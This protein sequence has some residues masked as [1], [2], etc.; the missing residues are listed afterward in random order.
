[1]KYFF[2]PFKGK[3]VAHT[4]IT[5]REPTTSTLIKDP[6]FKSACSGV[7]AGLL[8]KQYILRYYLT[9]INYF[10]KR[11]EK[12]RQSDND[13]KPRRYRLVLARTGNVFFS[14]ST[15]S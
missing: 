6:Q 9:K 13:N 4:W 14:A 8:F 11:E 7:Q 2:I 12:K 1:M 3:R 5:N 15:Q 10:F